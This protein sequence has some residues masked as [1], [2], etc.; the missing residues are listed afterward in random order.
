VRVGHPGLL[1]VGM[2]LQCSRHQILL[3]LRS[4]PRGV[5]QRTCIEDPLWPS[6][7]AATSGSL[8]AARR[9]ASVLPVEQAHVDRSCTYESHKVPRHQG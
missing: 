3:I 7:S 1:E 8:T 6:E 9:C 2:E 4:D 5:R